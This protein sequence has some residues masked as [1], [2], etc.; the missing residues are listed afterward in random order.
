MFGVTGQWAG[1]SPSM[2]GMVE[3][4]DGPAG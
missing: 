2:A 1:G 3:Y 4:Q